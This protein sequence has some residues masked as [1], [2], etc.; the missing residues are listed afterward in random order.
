MFVYK[1]FLLNI[2]ECDFKV[3]GVLGRCVLGC[4]HN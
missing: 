4:F 1:I 3:I 2:C